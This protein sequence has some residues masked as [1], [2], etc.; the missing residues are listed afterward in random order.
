MSSAVIKLSPHKY[1]TLYFVLCQ[2]SLVFNEEDEDE[3][4][5][6]QSIK[7]EEVEDVSPALRQDTDSSDSSLSSAATKIQAGVRG[8]LTRRQI[9]VDLTFDSIYLLGYFVPYFWNQSAVLNVRRIVISCFQLGELNL[10]L[11]ILCK[12]L[13][14]I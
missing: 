4:M 1:Y 5:S 11:K 7:T 2:D 14:L 3:L 6:L 13:Y 10:V 9:Q 12:L 8:Y